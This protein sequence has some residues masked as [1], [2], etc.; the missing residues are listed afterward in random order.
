VLFVHSE[1]KPVSLRLQKFSM[2]LKLNQLAPDFSLF[3]TNKKPIALH[4]FK[5][6]NV[7]L[8][9]FPFAFSSTCT[10]EVCELRDNYSYYENLDSEV[11]GISVDSLYTNAKFKELNQLNFPLLS[12]FN[13]EV[14]RLYDA[15]NESFAF[16]YH[17]VSRRATFVIDKE[18]T[19]VYEEILASSGDYPNME[20]LKGVIASLK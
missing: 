5:G 1:G 20:K 8:V 16:D 6:K 19:L 7:V 15:L 14:S 3:D 17:G 4:D 10:K 13:K 18:G 9:F 11:L 2:P 12:D